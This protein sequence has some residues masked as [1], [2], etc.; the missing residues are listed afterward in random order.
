MTTRRKKKVYL[1]KAEQADALA[2]GALNLFTDARDKL[3]A[4][5]QIHTEIVD[6]NKAII[7]SLED[8]AA[9]AD[10]ARKANA[11]VIDR[12]NALVGA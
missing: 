1:T 8:E 4:A 11:A 10:L 2:F 7:A 3:V 9:E 6:G 12:L 5:N